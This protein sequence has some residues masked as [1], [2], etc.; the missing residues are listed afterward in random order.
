M[1]QLFSST[2]T[3]TKSRKSQVCKFERRPSPS[4]NLQPL[5]THPVFLVLSPCTSFRTVANIGL[6]QILPILF[7][8]HLNGIT[9]SF[10]ALSRI[11]LNKCVLINAIPAV[12]A[13]TTLWRLRFLPPRTV[14]HHHTPYS[15]PV[16]YRWNGSSPGLPKKRTVV[17]SLGPSIAI[18]VQRIGISQPKPVQSI[19]A[20]SMLVGCHFLRTFNT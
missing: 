4:Y 19:G 9:F 16:S 10:S 7:M 12:I 18:P 8:P 3:S 6:F 11:S 5:P 2:S 17:L 14:K 20:G 1:D 13:P 15:A